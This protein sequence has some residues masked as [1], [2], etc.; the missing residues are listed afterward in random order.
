MLNFYVTLTQ[1]LSLIWISYVMADT[2]SL[3]SL[4]QYRSSISDWCTP[5]DQNQAQNK[6]MLWDKYDSKISLYVLPL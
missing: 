2:R 4:G 3:R 6:M 1:K 5:R